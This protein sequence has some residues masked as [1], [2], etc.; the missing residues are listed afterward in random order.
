MGAKRVLVRARP[1]TQ[2][3]SLVLYL[4][5]YPHPFLALSTLRTHPGGTHSSSRSYTHAR[6]HWRSYRRIPAEKRAANDGAR[7]GPDR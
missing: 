4:R 7:T 3:S 1:H 5:L 2:K 6:A